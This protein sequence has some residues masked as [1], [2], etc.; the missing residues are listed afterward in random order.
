MPRRIEKY[1][2]VVS[3][4]F[5]NY[6]KRRQCGP[7]RKTKQQPSPLAGR[8]RP[9][10]TSS[11]TSSNAIVHLIVVLSVVLLAIGIPFY[12]SSCFQ[13]QESTITI[14][15]P[16]ISQPVACP[17]TWRKSFVCW[18]YWVKCNFQSNCKNRLNRSCRTC[19]KN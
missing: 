5:D 11:A 9:I 19:R 13:S 4:E 2:H 3:E 18:L 16:G 14:N 15:V 12:W 7:C 8:C 10:Q 1:D 6:E 17:E